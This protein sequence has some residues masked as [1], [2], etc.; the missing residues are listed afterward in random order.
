MLLHEDCAYL[1]L[2]GHQ[3]EWL[4]TDLGVVCSLCSSRRE[5]KPKAQPRKVAA[6]KEVT[7]E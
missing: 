4:D 7:N 3:G 5:E 1:K 6:K 2:G